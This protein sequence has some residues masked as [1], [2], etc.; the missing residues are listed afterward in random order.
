MGESMKKKRTKKYRPRM[1]ARNN[2]H[3]ALGQASLLTKEEVD[4]AM[5]PFDL[6]IQEAHKGML[7]FES[8]I[9]LQTAFTVSYELE[10]TSAVRGLADMIA[11]VLDVLV[12]ICD[13]CDPTRKS[14]TPRPCKAE[15]LAA[16]K[17]FYTAHRF[18]MENC[19]VREISDTSGKL[20]RQTISKGGSDDG[21]TRFDINDAMVEIQQR[22][23]NFNISYDRLS[24][25][26]ED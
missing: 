15:E 21:R 19:T 16:L 24:I 25:S 11:P 5:M 3:I 10:R 18:Q 4:L 9:F 14:W 26:N 2:L 20:K 17:D 23:G 6:A 1:V 7:S 8:F 12:A 22:I 13:R